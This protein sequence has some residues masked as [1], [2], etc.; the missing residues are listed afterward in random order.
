MI[1]GVVNLGNTYN[2]ASVNSCIFIGNCGSDPEVRTF[3]NGEKVVTH[4]LGVTNSYKNKA[5]EKI[6][7]TEWIKLEFWGG[8]AS[9]AEQYTKKGSPIYIEGKYK[10]DT[11]EKDGVKHQRVKIRVNNLVLLS[12]SKP[13]E[14]QSGQYSSMSQPSQGS[15]SPFE[16]EDDS[17]E[18]PF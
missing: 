11:W 16:N 3:D 5:G 13:P 2:M 14:P 12:G 1:L 9:V 17:D 15:S 10:T 7:E 6:S 8:V 4:S 18:L